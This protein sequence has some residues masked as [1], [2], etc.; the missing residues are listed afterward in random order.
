MQKVLINGKW[1]ESETGET[2]GSINPATQE[3]L[4]EVPKCSKED[5]KRAIE[6]AV[7]AQ[8]EIEKIPVR[9]RWKLL[10]K[11]NE[12]FHAKID[13]YA[14]LLTKELGC[15]PREAREEVE[16]YAGIHFR[17]AAEELF[18]LRGEVCQHTQMEDRSKINIVIHEPLGVV[19]VIG[20]Y[21]FPIDIPLIQIAPA[22]AIGN[23]VV[24][25]PSSFTPLCGLKAVEPIIEAGFP[26][27]A[28]NV[29]TGPGSTVGNE[30]VTNPNVAAVTMTGSVETGKM[31]AQRAG[32]KRTLLELGGTG[33]LIVL[34]DADI[35]AAVEAMMVG[36]WYKSG[37]VCTSS[38]RILIDQRV[39]DEVLDKFI[40]EVKKLKVGEP[41]Q[42]NTDFGP[43]IDESQC[44]KIDQ[45]V[46]DAVDKG[47]ELLVGGERDGLFYQATVLDGITQDMDC[48]KRET[49]GPV[50]K[51][52]TFSTLEEC[53]EIANSDQYG[54]NAAVFT[55][56][57]RK[58]FLMAQA[59]KS[60]EVLI[61]ETTNYWDQMGPF[62][63]AKNSGK[64]RELSK[65]GMEELSE[66]KLI[67]FDYSNVKDSD[68]LSDFWG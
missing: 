2:F 29:V 3:V 32:L 37:Q 19:G 60:G 51:I 28:I 30:L 33:P 53:I 14:A 56:S 12:I 9:T 5:M 6:R 8:K 40:S 16:I 36:C 59:I 34:D 31:I 10:M 4:D 64:G 55:S 54:L 48:A 22:L 46:K 15:V 47:A 52:S 21:N 7:K 66:K 13:E 23:A 57:L 62:G 68:V 61:N 26:E 39:H 25:K 44:Q 1:V 49:F 63:G 43:I 41:T 27:G 11:A 20:P 17:V 65:W 24:F 58:A 18:R 67:V 50:A 35:D 42:E 45:H 38:E